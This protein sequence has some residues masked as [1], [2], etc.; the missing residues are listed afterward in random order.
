MNSEKKSYI[1]RLLHPDSFLRLFLC[2]FCPPVAVADKG[3]LVFSIVFL[4]YILQISVVGTV[5]VFAISAA[6]TFLIDTQLLLPIFT[7]LGEIVNNSTQDFYSFLLF[8]GA[9]IMAYTLLVILFIFFSVMMFNFFISITSFLFLI[10]SI[11]IALIVCLIKPTCDTKI[12][13]VLKSNYSKLSFFSLQQARLFFVGINRILLCYIFPPL[14]VSDMGFKKMFFVLLLTL[15]GWIPG[16]I[17]V[18]FC[19]LKNETI[20]LKGSKTNEY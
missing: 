8:A 3:C 6:A 10:P 12:V 14:A 18:L 1:Q 17:A 4:L 19:I 5:V 7:A 15:C 16:V 2:F 20:N 11:I 13:P 9:R